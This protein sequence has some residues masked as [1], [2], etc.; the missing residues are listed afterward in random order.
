MLTIKNRV[1]MVGAAL[2]ALA[3]VAQA[4]PAVPP[5]ADPSV[6]KVVWH[7]DFADP[8]RLSALIQNV[9]NMVATYQGDLEEYD[10]RIVFLSGGIRFLTTDAL[11]N[12]PFAE[13]KE[14]KARRAELIQRLQQLRE[15]MNVKLELCEI[16]R[17]A[18]QLP[19][20]KIIPGVSSVRSGVVRIAELQHKGYAYLKVE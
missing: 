16:T 12:T 1:V 9:N 18:L 10:V 11:A 4:E 19:T 13:D 2:L 15:V 5:V 20:G 17:E 7:A 8:R 3:A 6:K 14:L